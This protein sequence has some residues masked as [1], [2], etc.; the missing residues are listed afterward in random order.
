MPTAMRVTIV[1]AWLVALRPSAGA[2][3]LGNP[4]AADPGADAAGKANV[5]VF[6][7]RGDPDFAKPWTTPPRELTGAESDAPRS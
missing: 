7:T 5:R 4:A 6:S 1:L 2:A 3:D